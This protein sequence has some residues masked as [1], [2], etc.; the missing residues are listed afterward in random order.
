MK[1]KAIVNLG[2]ML[3]AYPDSMGGSLSETVA[4]LKNEWKGAFRSI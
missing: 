2:P 1:N 4:L 3:N